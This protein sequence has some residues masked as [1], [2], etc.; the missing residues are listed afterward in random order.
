MRNHRRLAIVA[1]VI[2]LVMTGAAPTVEAGGAVGL[3]VSGSGFGVS[4]GFGDWGIY[5]SAWS[6]PY[7]SIDF[8]ASLAGYGR[9]VW[10]SGLGRVWRPWVAASWR[11][12][13]YGRWV[14]TS[15]GLTWVSYEPWGYIPHH[16]GSWAYSSFG[17]VWQPGYSYSCAN[18]VWVGGG[19]YVGWYARPPWGWSHASH[20]FRH[21][22]HHGYRDGYGNGYRDG[23]HDARYGTYVS[24]HDFG[25]DN[26]SRHAVSHRT[27]SR[28]R[29]ES[30]GTAPTSAEIRRRGGVSLAEARLSR[31]TATVDGREITLARPEGVARSIER[32]AADTAGRALSDEALERRQPL[33]RRSQDR[34]P[35]SA[36]S[37]RPGG[38]SRK[39]PQL[40]AA[41]AE[42]A[43]L[44][45]LRDSAGASRSSTGERSSPSVSS[46]KWAGSRSSQSTSRRESQHIDDRQTR[47][48]A[49]TDSRRP[50]SKRAQ[51]APS[52][53]TRSR[54][55]VAQRKVADRSRQAAGPQLR[56]QEAQKQR[57][58]ATRGKPP[59][60]QKANASQRPEPR[61]RRSAA[62]RKQQDSA[63]QQSGQASRQRRR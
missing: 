45:R 31:R 41:R 37:S 13:T 2:A 3:H 29:L 24:W 44:S 58:A 17:W 51:S 32:H 53:Q 4:V 11:P 5:T 34:A 46:R 19:G 14:N 23:W 48:G 50:A 16:Y 1:P 20:G 6:D 25:T 49:R 38:V 8:N 47:P 63:E 26:V 52:V 10:V 18:V 12:Y 59:T 33:V 28:S 62:A 56:R 57:S 40:S 15:C 60:R 35:A 42:D 22:Y 9:W 39:I 54:P 30:L 61:A 36:G 55:S 21:G 7:W 27:A 43:S